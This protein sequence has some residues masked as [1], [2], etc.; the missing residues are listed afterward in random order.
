MGDNNY[1]YPL[2]ATSEASVQEKWDQLTNKAKPLP[3]LVEVA[4]GRT[5][6]VAKQAKGVAI[7]TFSELCEQAKGSSDY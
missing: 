6:H 7:V 4:Q 1:F 2:G 3:Q 5:L